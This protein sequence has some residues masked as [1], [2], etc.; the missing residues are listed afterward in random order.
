M[1][2]VTLVATVSMTLSRF[3]PPFAVVP[4][5]IRIILLFSLA[6]LSWTAAAFAQDYVVGKEDIVKIT[7][8]GHQD[9]TTVARVNGE[10][11]INLPLIGAVNVSGLTTSQ[12][13]Q[14][15]TDHLADGYI[16]DPNVSVFV[17]EYRSKK[18][19]I[20]GQITRP[21]VYSLSGN[22]S[23]LELLSKAGGLTKEAGDRAIVKR[24]SVNS[25]KTDSIIT[26]D[27][28]K[29]LEEGDTSSDVP[30]MDGDSVYVGK[31][32]VFY[33]TGEVKRPEAYKHEEGATVIKA[34]TMAGGF[35][36]K[37]APGRIRIIRKIRGKERIIEKAGMDEP[38]LPDD[39]IVVPESFW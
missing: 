36:D 21:G 35:T 30:L 16:V 31:A 12:I 23:L 39:I 3:A 15:V 7:V 11:L 33:V 17:E 24:K 5:A 27:L 13:A 28:R 22:T 25:D 38:V 9:L 29:L 8:Y 34:A 26:V 20:M 19:I 18:T 4:A 14:K 10:G 2:P 1:K 37:A 32:E 6:F